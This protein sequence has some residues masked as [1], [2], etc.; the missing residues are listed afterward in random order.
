MSAVRCGLV[1]GWIELRQAFSGA[2]L[3]GQLFWPF[4][5]LVALVFLRNRQVSAGGPM[6]GPVILP[7]LLGMFVAFGM[8]QQ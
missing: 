1:G 4:V 3:L 6:L 7:G 5:T 8:K 2:S